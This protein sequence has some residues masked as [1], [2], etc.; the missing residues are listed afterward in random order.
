MTPNRRLKQA[1]ELRGWSQAKVAEQIGTDATTVSRWERGL[2]SPTPY[3]RERLCAL[4]DKNAEEL[5]LLETGQLPQL[6]PVGAISVDGATIQAPGSF[7]S[8]ANNSADTSNRAESPAHFSRGSRVSTNPL[9]ASRVPERYLGEDDLNEA[10]N[11]LPVPS[12]PKRTDTFTYILHS[13]AH[14]Q[15]AHMLWEDAYV[16]A[17]RGQRAEAQQLAEASL[18]EF[19]RVG[20]L[21]AAAVREWLHQREL[22]TPASASTVADPS[23]PLS[24]SGEQ[25]KRAGRRSARRKSAGIVLI[26]FFVLALMLAGFSFSQLYTVGPLGSLLRASSSNSGLGISQSLGAGAASRL[27]AT[28]SA[29]SPAPAVATSTPSKIPTATPVKSAPPTPTVVV[30]AGGT[31]SSS[32]LD[33][34][35]TP[36]SLTPG[37]CVSDSIGWRCTL[38]LDVYDPTNTIHGSFS[39]KAIATAGLELSSNAGNTG[40]IGNTPLQ[41]IMYVKAAQGQQGTIVF[42]FTVPSVTSIPSVSVTWQS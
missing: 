4:F 27:T 19:E 1:R 41:V 22:T 35:V 12:W 20:H 32:S 23:V 34:T 11:S 37:T 14:D 30:T 16:R 25:R 33:T 18:S 26:L 9:S 28:T 15:Q 24:L 38:L 36:T 8:L 29:A 5:G 10:L 7:S 2:F 42:T 31:T 13:A 17:L 3:F 39:W 40:V 6:E 21:N